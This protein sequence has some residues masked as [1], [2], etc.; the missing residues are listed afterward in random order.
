MNEIFPNVSESV[1]FQT[2]LIIKKALEQ[3]DPYRAAKIVSD[4]CGTLT[5][6]EEKDYVDFCF[7]SVL[8]KFQKEN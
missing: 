1:R 8:Q 7:A 4:F 3:V 2:S 5:S 6:L